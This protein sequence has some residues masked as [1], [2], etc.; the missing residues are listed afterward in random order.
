MNELHAKQILEA[1][2]EFWSK[3]PNVALSPNARLLRNGIPLSEEVETA[4]KG[5]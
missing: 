4:L 1:I 3:Y 5:N 2:M